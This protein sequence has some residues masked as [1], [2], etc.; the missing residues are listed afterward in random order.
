ML[1]ANNDQEAMSMDNAMLYLR[2]ANFNS[3]KAVDIYKNYQVM[4]QARSCQTVDQLSHLFCHLKPMSH[5]L[6]L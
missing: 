6:S 5:S 1:R 2:A 3:S 4:K